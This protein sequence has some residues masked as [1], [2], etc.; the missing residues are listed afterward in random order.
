VLTVDAVRNLLSR[1]L[2]DALC[3]ACLAAACATSESDMR[4]ATEALL[5]SEPSFHRGSY[6]ATCR[7]AVPTVFYR[8]A[9]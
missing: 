1:V 6:C 4:A 3:D 8:P 9:S 7:R 5:N 2:T